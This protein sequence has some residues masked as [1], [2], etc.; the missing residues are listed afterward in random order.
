MQFFTTVQVQQ[1]LY[2]NLKDRTVLI[3][4]HRLST[5]ENASRIIV[6][7][8]GRIVE[9][10]THTELLRHD[11]MYAQLVKRQLLGFESPP[12]GT[13]G[14]VT[15]ETARDAATASSPRSDSVAIGRYSSPHLVD[16]LHAHGRHGAASTSRSSPRVTSSHV[17][18]GRAMQPG[19]RYSVGSV[20]SHDGSV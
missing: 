1:A 14:H 11:A 13:G 16:V 18:I 15:S 9:Q 5:V 10:G 20:R 4:A 19:R 2:E 3:I 12:R 8:K 7:D 17:D 6:I